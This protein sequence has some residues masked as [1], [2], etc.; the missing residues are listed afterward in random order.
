M[1]LLFLAAASFVVMLAAIAQ[2]VFVSEHGQWAT[3]LSVCVIVNAA[4]SA[5]LLW[6]WLN[7]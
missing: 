6:R 5:F 3:V 2:L 7:A 1:M 4:N